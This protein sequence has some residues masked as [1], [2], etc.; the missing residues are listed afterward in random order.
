MHPK[1]D[2][3]VHPDTE[4]FADV[5]KDGDV[6]L[7]VEKVVKSFG[8]PPALKGVDLTVRRGRVHAL[9]GMNGAGKS[10]LV[11]IISGS[12]SPTSGEITVDGR[13]FRVMTP[14]KAR[15]HGVAT[16]Y[17]KRTLI[18]ELTVGE[19]IF[20]GEL[21]RQAGLV[22]WRRIHDGA[23]AAL[24]GIGVDIDPA[25]PVAALGAARQTLVEIARE[26][27][28]GA[29]VLILDEPTAALGAV[30]AHTVHEVVRRLA[31]N[32]VA[33]VYISHHLSEVFDI[34]D[35]ATVLRDGRVV[36]NT[37]I[38]ETTLP[39]LITSMVGDIVRSERPARTHQ[40]G[41]TRLALEGISI[42]ARL[43]GF[44]VDVRAGEIVAVLGPAGAGQE[45][46]FPILSG[47]RKP[48]AGTVRVNGVA[49]SPGSVR[50]M[51]RAGVRSISVD[52]LG[53]GLVGMASVSE[54]ITSFERNR[55][56]RGVV[57]WRRLRARAD[58]L[59]A[60]F[61]VV[62]LD[63]DPSVER[64]SGGNQQK[65]LLA[66]W[67]GD[68][69]ARACL[70][71]EPTGGVD[72]RAKAEVHAFIDELAASGTGVLLASSDVDEVLRLA[73]RILV[74]RGRHV[75]AEREADATTHQ[76]LISIVLGGEP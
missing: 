20:A 36:L 16:V 37:T 22:N 34:A 72:I 23:A 55:F 1:E 62:S 26:V 25:L 67:L 18:G 60:R 33:V 69:T 65:V 47:L 64:L 73:D 35:D 61:H 24:Q 42:D 21:P 63:R 43:D 27:R 48:A 3:V 2:S 6:V 58:E 76:E 66:K 52:R 40:L 8:G 68:G 74:V 75:V 5:A 59:R 39:A 53:S 32:G 41:S 19:N 30:D 49:V 56:G 57:K 12:L 10:T 17:Q 71:E 51:L 4:T 46:L 31:A 15:A 28:K 14:R 70:L 9:L 38:A 44:S 50:R 54:N 7:R 45:A 29:S 11:Q 13:P